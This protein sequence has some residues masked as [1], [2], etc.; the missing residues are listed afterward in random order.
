MP[1]PHNPAPKSIVVVKKRVTIVAEN[2]SRVETDLKKGF[3][4]T[5]F[6]ALRLIFRLIKEM[7]FFMLFV[8]LV[9]LCLNES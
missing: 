1:F 5:S 8:V 2:F 6:E 7:L 3:R 9:T 4:I